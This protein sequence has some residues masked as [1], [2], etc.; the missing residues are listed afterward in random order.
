M[1]GPIRS[2]CLIL[3]KKTNLDVLILVEL[4]Q[5]LFHYNKI[6]AR[7]LVNEQCELYAALSQQF[8]GITILSDHGLKNLQ[9]LHGHM[10][11]LLWEGCL[12]R[13]HLKAHKH[14]IKQ[15][16]HA[17]LVQPHDRAVS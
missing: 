12:I 1:N 5:L 17:A 3:D 14:E 6:I 9:V 15:L 8:G 4:H 16:L 11:D 2:L 10:I 13:L 7:K